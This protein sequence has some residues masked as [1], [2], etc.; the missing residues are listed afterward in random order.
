MVS[1]VTPNTMM[2]ASRLPALLGLSK[3]RSPNDELTATISALK[4]E[5]WPDIGNEAMDW[6]NQLEPIILREAARRLELTDL[7]TEHPEPFFHRDFPLACSLD[8]SADGRGQVLHTDPDAGIY[9]VGQDSIQLDGLG[10]LEAKLTSQPA[11]DMPPLWRGPIQLQA[12]MAILG[13]KWGCIATLYQGTE[14]RLF[15]FAPHEQTLG[16]IRS[17]CEDFQRRLLHWKETGAVDFYPPQSSKDADRMYPQSEPESIVYLDDSAQELAMKILAAKVRI[18]Q[19]ETDRADAEKKLKKL[20]G[21]ASKAVAGNYLV[22]WPMRNYQA[23]PAKTVPA[24]E[25]YSIRQ[26]T[27]SIKEI[28]P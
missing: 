16:A 14:L 9:V 3:Y 22:S 17:A 11:E 12:Q 18:D 4:G 10:V 7:I 27:L 24:K 5:D 19:A 25:A 1:K 21:T 15:L 20:I 6:G 13:A 26:S 28:R 23:Q 2:S 8:G